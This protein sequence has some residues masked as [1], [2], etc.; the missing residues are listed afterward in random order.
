VV[1]ALGLVVLVAIWLPRAAFQ[2]DRVDFITTACDPASHSY[3]VTAI[4]TI[5][6]AGSLGGAAYIELLIDG[7]VVETGHYEIAAHES[8]QRGLTAIV[9]DCLWHR[10][11]VQVYTPVESGG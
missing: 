7:A 5:R 10:F 1:V 11:A 9:H 6:N 8:V 4:M 2:I 3:Q